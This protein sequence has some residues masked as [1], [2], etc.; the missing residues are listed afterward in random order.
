MP[1]EKCRLNIFSAVL[2]LVFLF[3]KITNIYQNLYSKLSTCALVHEK[4]NFEG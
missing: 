2:I 3:S 1:E 4:L